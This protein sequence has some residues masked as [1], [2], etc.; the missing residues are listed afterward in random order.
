MKKI[1]ALIPARG[2]S[3][4]IPNKPLASLYKHPLIE[5]TIQTVLKSDIHEVWVS[6]DS[7]QILGFAASQGCK[8]LKRP[9]EFATDTASIESVIEHFGQ[10]VDYHD[11][12]LVQVTSPLLLP[13]HINKALSIYLHNSDVYDSAFSGYY[14]EKADMLFWDAE[15]MK[16]VNY[17]P[18]QRGIRQKRKIKHFVESGGFY[19]FSKKM[20]DEKKCRIG[21]KPL[22]AEIPFWSSFEV[23]TPE[24]LKMIEKL[25]AY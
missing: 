12:V 25:I 15:M 9:K 16:A 11:M 8:T 4:G 5:Y 6:S 17:D 1:V 10:N 13:Q 20:F 3:K 21:D 19:I 23:D 14:M 24:D 2:G 7:D 18:K 22:F